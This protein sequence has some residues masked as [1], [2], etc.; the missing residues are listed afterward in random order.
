MALEHTGFE[1]VHSQRCQGLWPT[2]RVESQARRLNALRNTQV[3]VGLGGRDMERWEG[4]QDRQDRRT[5]NRQQTLPPPPR[6][7]TAGTGREKR[8][9]RPQSSRDLEERRRRKRLSE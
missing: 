2:E 9:V 5:R 3:L 4:E 1:V 7:R 6:E 8:H